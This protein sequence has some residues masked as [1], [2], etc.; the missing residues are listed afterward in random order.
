[1]KPTSFSQRGGVVGLE[2]LES[3]RLTICTVQL[4][5]HTMGAVG[6]GRVV[7]VLERMVSGLFWK[8][9]GQITISG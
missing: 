2:R 3:A 6:W 7:V 8:M 9:S 1:M 5:D 4:R